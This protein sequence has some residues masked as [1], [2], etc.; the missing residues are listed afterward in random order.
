VAAPPPA[1]TEGSGTPAD[2]GP[3]EIDHGEPVAF[4]DSYAPRFNVPQAIAAPRPDAEWNGEG[5]LFVANEVGRGVSVF[6]VRTLQPVRF[7]YSPDS[8]VPHH[9]YIS[10]DQRWV[11]ANAR[12]GHE[13]M[14]IDTHDDFATTFLGFPEGEDGDVAGPLHGVY[15]SDSSRFLVA[16]QR[17]D[18]LG[19]VDLTGDEPRIEEVIDVGRRPR[20]VYITPDDGKAF[21][22]L[23]NDDRVA[24][25]DIG[26]WEVRHVQRSDTDYADG[27][28]G[29]GGM[30]EDGSLFAV[31][32]TL[33]DEVAIIDTATEEV[34]QRIAD[35]PGPVNAEFLGNTHL[36]GTGNRADGSVSIMDA[37]SGELQGTTVTGGGANI[38][39][40]GPDGRIWVTHNGA[41]HVSILDPDTLEVVEEVTTGQNPHWLYFTPHGNMAFVTN[42]GEATVSLLDTVALEEVA[43]FT[44]G[45]NPNGRAMK[46]DVTPE[47]AEQ[48]RAQAAE[49]AELDVQLAANLVV[50]E[51]RSE[52]EELFLDT[53]M[54]CHDI[55]RIVRNNSRGDQWVP[56]VERMRRNGAQM[57]DEEMA[58]IIDYLAAGEHQDLELATEYDERHAA[59]R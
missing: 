32:N 16:L 54:Q 18:R 45:L 36:V 56:I 21:V 17:S 7:I 19:V 26:T 55:G 22:S 14:V 12:F 5:W 50:P 33:D 49:E 58:A 31:S 8:P 23:Q 10:P 11:A 43:R 3:E 59:D 57:S 38:P 6:D 24:V 27:E 42:W 20:D 47:L 29:G 28:G 48:V 51:P 40:L 37:D 41:T 4:A 34:V 30:S 35:V 15:T 46:T 2:E 9:P 39:Q 52:Q 13:V 53:C 25:V 1:D 44:T